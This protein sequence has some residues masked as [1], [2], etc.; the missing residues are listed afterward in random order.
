[1]PYDQEKREFI[2]INLEIPVR[3]KFICSHITS[4]AIEKIYRGSSNNISGGGLLLVGEIPDFGWIPDLLLHKIVVGVN[5]LLPNEETMIKALSRV[6]WIGSLDE[7][8]HQAQMGLK[9]QELTADDKDS[10]LRFVIK[11]Q[12]PS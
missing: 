5:F 10:V 1:M 9:F 2:R 11:S 3:Y 6:T 12:L 8:T 7:K 4:P